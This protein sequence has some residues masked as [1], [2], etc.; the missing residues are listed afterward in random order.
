[1]TRAT[2]TP[3]ADGAA[4]SSDVHVGADGWLFLIGGSNWVSR[5]YRNSPAQW[6][7]TI[8]WWAL[9]AARARRA[10]RAG[11]DYRHVVV[12]EKVAVYDHRIAG[13]AVKA[14]RAPARRLRALARFWPPTRKAVVDILG[15][16]RA[17][18]DRS[19]LY[20]RT[21]THWSFEGALV[22]YRTVCQMVGAVARDFEDREVVVVPCIGDLGAKLV[23][24][25]PP[26]TIRR[27]V[28]IQDAVRVLANPLV[29][30]FEAGEDT[31]EPHVGT[32]VV[33][34]NAAVDAD[35]RSVVLFGDS[36]AHYRTDMPTGLLTA[37]R[38]GFGTRRRHA[39]NLA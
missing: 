15:P 38:F 21:D 30:R 19:D 14:R 11:I 12:P 22:A 34:R 37:M 24:S 36:Y 10:S 17:A 28:V 39:R 27:R 18:R 25:P 33:Y 29:T 26:E 9:I 2:L 16:L 7:R 1:M 31:R 4:P 3:A 6:W 23:P 13:F 5:Q 32:R 20:L 35:R 8:R